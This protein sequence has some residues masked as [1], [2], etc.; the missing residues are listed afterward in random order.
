MTKDNKFKLGEWV[1]NQRDAYKAG[2]LSAER[3]DRFE[4]LGFVWVAPRGP[5]RHR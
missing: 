2:K 1:R 3:I 5:R 4:A